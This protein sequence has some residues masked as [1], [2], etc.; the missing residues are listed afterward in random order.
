[1]DS[2]IKCQQKNCNEDATF[3]Y[4]WA[5]REESHVCMVCALKLANVAAAMS[6]PLQLIPLDLHDLERAKASAAMADAMQ[7][8]AVPDAS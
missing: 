3:R 7:S 6:Y 5:G 2:W 4:T 1:M 8:K